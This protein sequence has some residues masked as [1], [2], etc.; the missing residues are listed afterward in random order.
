MRPPKDPH[1][2]VKAIEI[3][4]KLNRDASMVSRLCADYETTRDTKTEKKIAEV[5]GE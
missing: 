3:A 4:R 2:R 5:I 1:A